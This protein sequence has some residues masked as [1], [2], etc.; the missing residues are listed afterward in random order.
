VIALSLNLLF[1]IG[2]KRKASFTIEAPEAASQATED[3]FAKQGGAWGARPDIIRRATFAVAQLAEAVFENC[4]PR[5]P[6]AVSASFDEFNVDVRIE[7][8][9]ALLEFPERRPTDTEIRD[10]DDGVR[11]LAGFMLRHNADRVRADR[12]GERSVALFH[13]DH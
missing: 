5:G 11:R 10:G 3:F 8:A 2:V 9:G 1:R 12:A 7:Y 4:A 13:F 6:I